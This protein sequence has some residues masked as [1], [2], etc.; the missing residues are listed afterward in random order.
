MRWRQSKRNGWKLL[1]SAASPLAI[2]LARLGDP[3]VEQTVLVASALQRQRGAHGRA[4]RLFNADVRGT[5][6]LRLQVQRRRDDKDDKWLLLRPPCDSARTIPLEHDAA[7][8]GEHECGSPCAA[9]RLRERGPRSGEG[10]V[11]RRRRGQG[12]RDVPRP[13]RRRRCPRT[14]GTARDVTCTGQVCTRR[15]VAEDQALFSRRQAHEDQA[16]FMSGLPPL[17]PLG[18]S[19]RATTTRQSKTLL[20]QEPPRDKNNEESFGGTSGMLSLSRTRG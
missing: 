15:R 16:Q 1:F 12:D 18:A 11:A 13:R 3:P 2:S 14:R 4:G 5:H 10:V 17:P 20:V 8:A 6:P 9:G 7:S 19:P